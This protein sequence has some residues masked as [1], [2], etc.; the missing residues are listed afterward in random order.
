MEL[1]GGFDLD[2]VLP[3]GPSRGALRGVVV[4]DIT[5]VV[6]GPFC[7][8]MLADL[9]ATVIKIENPKDPD[10][11]R[12]FPPLLT[13]P[14]GEAFSA[15]FA[16][17]NR[18]KLGMTL[19]L[20]RP[21]GKD[22]LRTLVTRADVLVENFRGGTMDKLGVGYREL[23]KINPRL[24]YTAISG[25]GQ[26]GP[27]RRKPAYDNSA[28]ATGGLWSMN[29]FPDRPPVRVGTIIGDLSATLYADNAPM[30]KL[31]RGAGCAVASDQ[32]DTGVEEVV[33]SV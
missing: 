31:I 20:S 11:A 21:E 23:R 15:F 32:I 18:N 7:S 16:Q 6:A 30:R 10:Y 26:T 4:L 8:M 1:N 13:S 9:G 17:Y 14:D 5:R 33:L 22:L 19:D 28:Q 27:Y 24:I 3:G 2:A 29:G 12:A 25:Y